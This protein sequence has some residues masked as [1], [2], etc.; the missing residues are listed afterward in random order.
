MG[1]AC[2]LW[3]QSELH[4]VAYCLGVWIN[5]NSGLALPAHRAQRRGQQYLLV[6][7]Y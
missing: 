4:K 1:A 2:G 5:P 7:L 3:P 6:P